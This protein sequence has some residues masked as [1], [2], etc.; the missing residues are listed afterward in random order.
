MR[1][2]SRSPR[3]LL[4]AA[5]AALSTQLACAQ[6]LEFAL[7]AQPLAQS[8]QELARKAGLQLLVDPAL[9]QGRQAPALRGRHEPEAALNRL[10]ADSGLAGRIEGRTLVLSPSAG[11]AEALPLVRARVAAEPTAPVRGYLA[12]SSG[13]AGKLALTLKETPQAITVLGAELLRDQAVASLGEAVRYAPGVRS[14]D[15]TITDDDM[16]LR[17]F[18][19]TGAGTYRDGLR[20]IHNGFMSNLEPYGL[21]RLELLRG[22]ASVTYGQAAPGGVV[23][24][25]TKRPQAGMTQEVGIKVGSFQRRELTL[26][27][28]GVLGAP[29]Q[30]LLWRFTALKRDAETQWPGL[31]DE[32]LYLA[33]ALSW[34]GGNTSITLMAQH[35]SGRTGYVIPYYRDTPAGPA[36]KDINVNGPD[37]HQDKTGNSIGYALEHQLGPQLKLVQNLRFMDAEN[38]RRD[39]R[40]RGLQADGR[41]IRRLAMF[42][43][44]KEHSLNIDSRLEAELKT[45]NIGHK[46][47][48]GLDYYRSTLDLRIHS[49]NKGVAPLDLI[50]P[51]YTPIA[52]NDNYLADRIVARVSQLG[53][54]AQDQLKFGE[55]W[56]ASVGGRWDKAKTDTSYDARLNA[57]DPFTRTEHRRDDTA[58]TG[59][60]GLVHL[61]PSGWSPYVSFTNSFQP[62]MS[63]TTAKD[64]YGQEFQPEK[65]RQW[66][67]GVRHEPA[68]AKWRASAAIFDLRKRHVRTTKEE[69]HPTIPNRILRNEY[70]TGEVRSRGLELEFSGEL[71]RN[72]SVQA[73]YTWL[74]AKV[75]KSLVIGEQGSQPPATPRHNAA[76]WGK[77]ALGDWS[78]GLGLRH[79]SGA[80][81][82]VRQPDGSQ[83]RNDGYTLADAMVS[84]QWGEKQAWRAALNISNLTDKQ[85]RTQCNLMPG[86]KDFCVIGY[87][88]DVR[89][90]LSYQW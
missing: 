21:E 42:R 48:L 77:Y 68:D 23:N 55:H 83:L 18:W 49:L 11:S 58:F 36:R 60:L 44:D 9:L 67:A 84:Y 80:P 76:L 56:V 66:E 86:G 79:I 22:P 46:L 41:S 3:L 14:A 20:F 30:G 4:I 34:T 65:G 62:V 32:R 54:Y 47:A 19:L 33:P 57:T 12:Q 51:V 78:L 7:P 61:S 53:L 5:A 88:R 52:W 45:G 73:Q 15:Y 82:E 87:G 69:P 63:T 27:V 40:N 29:E 43:P 90:N 39:M 10:L 71:A 2:S 75:L 26:D 6:A 74:D 16:A 13:S 50:A 85:Y 8:L 25:V 38:E 59:R 81:S 89:L 35:Q 37:G 31:P 70:Q 64:G 28:G 24:A 1:S 72:L 17:G